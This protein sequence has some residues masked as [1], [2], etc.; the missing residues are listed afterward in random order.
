MFIEYKIV[1]PN[2]MQEHGILNTKYIMSVEI[3]AHG[4]YDQS[5]N[6]LYHNS[7]E[8][9]C[10]FILD[11]EKLLYKVYFGLIEALKGHAV[12]FDDCEPELSGYIKPIYFKSMSLIWLK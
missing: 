1:I 9:K 6:I 7:Y 12:Y 3:D 2:E 8:G 4:G 11:N 5:I 10:F